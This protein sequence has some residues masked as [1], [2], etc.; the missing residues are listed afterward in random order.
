[1]GDITSEVLI[2]EGTMVEA[3]IVFKQEGVL[4]GI[5]EVSELF[6]MVGCEFEAKRKD[7]ERIEPGTVVGVVRGDARAILSAERTALNV[8][9]RM[10]GIATATKRL[11]EKVRSVSGGKV[12]VASTRK[13]AP[14][15][16]LF[17]KRA[18][19]VGGGDPHRSRLDDAVLI[20]DNHLSILGSVREAV[21]IAKEK[22]SFVKRVE[23]EVRSFQEAIEAAEA[24]ADA[25]LL[26]NFTPEEVERTVRELELRGLRKNVVIEVSGGIGEENVESYARAGVDVISVGYLT[27]SVK[28]ID[29]SLEVRRVIR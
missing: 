23:V 24:G 21:R 2:E 29:A 17:D 13:T 7:G 10:S 20:K 8:L 28:S 4:A 15:C 12:R 26:D 25:I 16:R 3:E 11:V 19:V 5:R 14:G 18:V 6:R 22:V 27:H 9:M 1:M